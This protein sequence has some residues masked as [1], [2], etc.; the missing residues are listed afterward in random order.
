MQGGEIFVPKIPSMKVV[1]LAEAMAPGLPL[2]VIG[3]RPG[4]KLHEAMCPAESA[5]LTLEFADHYVIMPTIEFPAEADY[6]RNAKGEVG[7]PVPEGFQY[8]SDSNTDWMT[9]RQL[10]DMLKS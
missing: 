6:S 7:K 5:Y 4:E 2:K 1:D 10:L 9:S 3:I 8:S